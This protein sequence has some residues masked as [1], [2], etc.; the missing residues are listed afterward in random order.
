MAETRTKVLTIVYPRRMRTIP[1]KCEI[2]GRFC[3]AGIVCANEFN[4]LWDTGA[5]G[6]VISKVVVSSLGL[7]PDGKARVCHADGM[8]VVDTY[9]V[10]LRLSSGVVFKNLIVTSG[11][12]MDTDVLIGMDVISMGD[13][14]ITAPEGVTKFSF[15][16]PSSHD[17]DFHEEK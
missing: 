14:A 13:F 9:T 10:D 1:T 6:S 4:A 17:I 11:N 15:Q 7:M 3:D 5:D 16:V 8:S 2:L 12:L